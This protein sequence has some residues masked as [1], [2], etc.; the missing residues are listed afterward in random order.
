MGVACCDTPEG[1]VV[2]EAFLKLFALRLFD[3]FEKAVNQ[4]YL[5]GAKAQTVEEGIAAAKG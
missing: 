2:L 3:V 1:D 4:L 5:P